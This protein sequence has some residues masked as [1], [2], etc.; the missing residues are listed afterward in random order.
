MPLRRLVAAGVRHAEAFALVAAAHLLIETTGWDRA[1]A[2]SDRLLPRRGRDRAPS[3]PEA[4]H[5]LAIA[6]EQSVLR[7]SRLIPGARC[8]PRALAARHMLA[9]RGI[10]SKL[11]V[12]LRL[13]PR[14]EGHAW[15]EI[16]T[17]PDLVRLFARDPSTYTPLDA[18]TGKRPASPRSPT[19]TP[20]SA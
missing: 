7:T 17:P 11:I 9:R 12:G 18:L 10:P 13:K 14:P 1:R 3:L 16:G 6:I 5:A 8:A 4:H 2:A 20:S 15:L 19:P